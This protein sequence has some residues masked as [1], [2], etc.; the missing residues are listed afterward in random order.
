LDQ[1]KQKTGLGI[2]IHGH[3][4]IL[5]YATHGAYEA[6]VPTRTLLIRRNAVD[7]ENAVILIV[8][9]LTNRA[10]SSIFQM[11]FGNGGTTLTDG[12]VTFNSPN[13]S[14]PNPNLYNPVFF[15]MVD[16][17]LGALP[18]NQMAIRHIRSSMFTD[19]EVR[20]LIDTNQ[21]FG[22]LTTNTV[23][24]E[25]SLPVI[26]TATT[27]GPFRSQFSFDEIGLFLADGTL[28]THVVF[29]PILKTANS[30]IEVVYTLRIAVGLP[31]P[32]PLVLDLVGVAAATSAG[33]LLANE[34]VYGSGD[35]GAG[36]YSE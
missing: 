36:F 7:K 18:G 32:E 8:K 15:Q 4:K 11:V 27:F 34:P 3:L 26:S 33:V 24:G 14:G 1:L 19:M 22:Q 12:T 29:V 9:A 17:T 20:C 10:T 6:K 35:Y 16:D 30:L 13:V 2:R 5:E 21:P 25:L 28:I 23:Q 31:P